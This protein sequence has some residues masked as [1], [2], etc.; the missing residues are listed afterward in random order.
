MVSAHVSKANEP[1][2]LSSQKHWY[3]PSLPTASVSSTR[4][5]EVTLSFSVLWYHCNVV[6]VPV[7]LHVKFMLSSVKRWYTVEVLEGRSNT[8][9]GSVV[10]RLIY[11]YMYT[12]GSSTNNM[13]LYM[14]II[15]F[16]QMYQNFWK[17]IILRG[18]WRNNSSLHT[19]TCTCITS[20][21]A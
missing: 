17:P 12:Q 4:V 10:K 6:P 3:T 2:S 19:C 18:P 21:Y 5:F 16:V 15:M 20:I 13:V 11:M 8:T 14:V 9:R 1:S 7:A